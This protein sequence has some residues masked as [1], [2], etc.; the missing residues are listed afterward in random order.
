MYIYTGKQI[1]E[2][3]SLAEQKGMSLF[4]LMENAGSGLYRQILEVITRGEK[5]VI[6]AGKGNNGGDGIVLA[7]YLKNNGYHA[8]LIFPLGLPKTK[9]AKEHLAYY[10]ACG[11]EI[12]AFAKDI[13]ADIVVD[14]LLG[15]GSQLP[16]RA[17]LADITDWINECSKVIAIDLPTGVSSDIGD[18]DE[19]AVHAHYTYALHGFKPSTFLFPSSEY[20][21]ETKVIDIGLQQESGWCVWGE[22]DVRDTLP[23][24]FGN[25]HKGTFGTG[26]LMGGC[27][28]MPGS[29]ALSAIGAVRFGIGKLSVVTTK[30]ASLFIGS[31]VPEATFIYDNLFSNEQQTFSSIAIGPGLNPNEELEDTIIEVLKQPIPVILDAGALSSRSYKKRHTPTILTPHPGEFSRLTGKSSMEIQSNRIQLA[32]HFAQDHDVIVVLKGSYTVIAFPDGTGIIN[33]TGN[34]ALSK[35]GTGDT[36]TGML[37]ASVNTHENIKE[38]VANT[39][40]LHGACADEWIKNH[41][42]QTMSAHD[43]D[44][45][46]PEVCYQYCH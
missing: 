10:Q 3:D 16:L 32:Q 23:K 5:V 19:H 13:K 18:V 27:D 31:F 4:A 17:D 26:L 40:Y 39:V 1:K 33:S 29:V 20:F 28:E 24:P 45:L 34:R 15:V 2:I 22:Q 7:R 35:G 38:A 44:L 14:G 11:Y 41:G 30:H 6:F 8:S 9:T 25:T 46:L 37:L 43:F 12:D 36:L 42:R 21:G